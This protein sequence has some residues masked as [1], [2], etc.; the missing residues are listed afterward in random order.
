MF[1]SKFKFPK[2]SLNVASLIAYQ[3]WLNFLEI[4][5]IAYLCLHLDSSIYQ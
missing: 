1:E 3:N 4:L 5:L 2:K